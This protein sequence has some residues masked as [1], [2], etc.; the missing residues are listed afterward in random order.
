[1]VW[2]TLLIVVGFIALWRWLDHRLTQIDEMFKV[3]ALGIRETK[4]EI[5]EDV[6]QEVWAMAPKN[7]D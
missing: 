6:I 3:L 1:M 4:K 5:I 2:M 7:R